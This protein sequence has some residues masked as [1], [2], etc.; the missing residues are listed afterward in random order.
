M[1][2][3][4]WLPLFFVFISFL[5]AQLIANLWVNRF[6]ATN[7]S[8]EQQKI[9][10]IA[11]GFTFSAV[12]NKHA[13]IWQ[14]K[15]FLLPSLPFQLNRP[16]SVHFFPSWSSTLLQPH[17]RVSLFLFW[18]QYNRIKYYWCSNKTKKVTK[19]RPKHKND[20][21]NDQKRIFSTEIVATRDCKKSR[22]R[23]YYS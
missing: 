2:R 17:S 8:Q 16:K 23:N 9:V 19:R 20:I 10:F 3:E 6:R 13:V 15:S 5:W 1:A 22:M 12:C 14:R 21:K 4:V 11:I 18:K 7:E